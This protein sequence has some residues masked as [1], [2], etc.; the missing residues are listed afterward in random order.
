MLLKVYGFYFNILSLFSKNKTAEKAF[1]LFSTVRKGKV[2]PNQKEFLDAAKYELLKIENHDIQVYRWAGAGD[3]VLL[4]HGWESNTY[5]WRNLIEKLREADFNIIA[6]DAPGHGY[7]SGKRLH[8]PL[9]AKILQNIL[10][11]H[12]S[13]HLIGHSVGGMTIIYNEYSNPNS[14]VEKIITVGAPSEFYEIMNHYQHLLRFNDRVMRA[15]DTYVFDRFGFRI[16]EFSTSE[17]IRT[18]TNKGLLFHDRLDRITPYHASQKVHAH[19]K[20]SR[21]ISTEGFGHSM[22][23]NEVNDA[24]VKFL[25]E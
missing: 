1:N 16:R 4:I 17:F 20:G 8:V 11:R 14:N 21:L 10:Q 5:R 12:R 6:F 25:K 9:Y 7:S 22:H 3:T 2:S 19:W 13:K 24:I 15:L 23:Q 18:N